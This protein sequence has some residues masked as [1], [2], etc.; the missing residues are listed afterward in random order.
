MDAA[1]IKAEIVSENLCAKQA[2]VQVANTF[3][4]FDR[5]LPEAI[6]P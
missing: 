6:T 4:N 1:K 5:D 3:G 2:I